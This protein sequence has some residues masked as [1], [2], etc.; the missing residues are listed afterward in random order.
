MLKNYLVS[1]FLSEFDRTCVL[2]QVRSLQILETVNLMHSGFP[3][4][5]RFKAFNARY[6]S[7]AT[8][9]KNL[10]RTDSKAVEDCEFILDCYSK[11]V[12]TCLEINSPNNDKRSH[13]RDWAH[14][15]KHIFLSEGA[16]QQLE[17]L[18]NMKIHK[19]ATLIQ[20]HWKVYKSRKQQHKRQNSNINNNITQDSTDSSKN[21]P[22]QNL[23]LLW[24]H[25]RRPKPISGTPPPLDVA[26]GD[27]CDFKTIQQT[28]S[29]FGLD[30][31]SLKL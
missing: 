18:R 20:N 2:D 25:S 1:L 14:G 22:D 30:L 10:H 17:S 5:M 21:G 9:M 24:H 26:S 6:K 11:Q 4:R 27:K 12:K 19:S 16:R 23:N 8:P 29:L 3:H 28:C 31:V 13:N 7:L 15:R